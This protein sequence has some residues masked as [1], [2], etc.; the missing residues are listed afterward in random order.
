ML[1]LRSRLELFPIGANYTRGFLT[2][3]LLLEALHLK[4]VFGKYLSDIPLLLALYEVLA[5]LTSTV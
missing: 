4:S 1:R 3:K 5:V 2:F